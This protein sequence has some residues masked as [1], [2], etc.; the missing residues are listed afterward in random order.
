MGEYKELKVRVW[1]KEIK[2]MTYSLFSMNPN[3][4]ISFYWNKEGFHSA[5]AIR[6]E[7]SGVDDDKGEKLWIGDIFTNEV[8]K[9]EVVFND[10]CF[11]GK[12]IGN[13]HEGPHIALRAIRGKVKI[14]NIYENPELLQK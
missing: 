13:L 10:G 2:K 1:D 5:H 3:G 7:Y 4:D 6:M 12:M 14:G 11:S 9:W 8:A